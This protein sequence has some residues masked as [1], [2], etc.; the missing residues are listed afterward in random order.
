MPDLWEWRGGVSHAVTAQRGGK[1]SED[2][3]VPLDRLEEAI[4]GTLEIG[5]RQLA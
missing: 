5:E 2:V 1:L 3:A 4:T